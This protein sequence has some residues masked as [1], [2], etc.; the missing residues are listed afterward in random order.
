M[1]GISTGAAAYNGAVCNTLGVNAEDG[2]LRIIN[3]GANEVQARYIGGGTCNGS[4]TYNGLGLSNVVASFFFRFTTGGIYCD[5]AWVPI[6]HLATGTLTGAVSL[7][8]FSETV[9]YTR[10]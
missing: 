1:L 7:S 8:G 5:S 10:G 3:P 9:V 4:I 6:D 2:D